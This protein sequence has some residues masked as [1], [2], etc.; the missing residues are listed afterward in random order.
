MKI[1]YKKRAFAVLMIAILLLAFTGSVVVSTQFVQAEETE[2]ETEAE[3]ARDIIN[4]DDM[5]G[6]SKI[7]GNIIID[8]AFV[9]TE[10]LSWLLKILI[11]DVTDIIL[12]TG[13]GVTK[14]YCFSFAE[15][16]VYGVLAA[17]ASV[18]GVHK[19]SIARVIQNTK[20]DDAAELVIVTEAVKEK[21]LEDALAH[22][23]DMDTTREIG[24][25]I[26]EY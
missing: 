6:V 16:N 2:A 13:N 24:T 25:V 12:Q 17:I 10:G 5:T 20:E 4:P 8:F 19:V 22:L 1:K 11:G 15:G 18:F 9:I 7:T 23:V 14:F 26:R 21:H 3:T